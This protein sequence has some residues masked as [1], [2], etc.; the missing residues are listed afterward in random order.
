[1]GL[2]FLLNWLP[3]VVVSQSD[4]PD[5]KPSKEGG[6]A[7]LDPR[8]DEAGEEKRNI[9]LQFEGVPYMDALQRFSQMAE[10]PL[11]TDAPLDGTLTFFDSEPYTYQEAMDILNVILSMKGVALVE[12]GRYLQ[13]TTLENIQKMP[14]KVVRGSDTTGDFRPGQ[15][16]TVVLRLKHLDAGEVSSAAASLLSNA[17]SVAPLSRG[18]GL[19]ITDRLESIH[20]IQQLLAEIDVASAVERDMK[21]YALKHASGAVVS[22]LINKTFGKSSVPKQVKWNEKAKKFDSFDPDP[23]SYISSVYDEASRTLVLFGPVETLELA[24]ELI[25]EF[26]TGEG[27]AGEVKIF[28]P[29]KMNAEELAS[30]IREGV[31]GVAQKGET[32]A[33]AKLKARIIVDAKLN[34]VIA[35]APV[36][37]QLEIIENFVLQVDGTGATGGQRKPVTT[38][39]ITRVFR[40][41]SLD[42][43]AIRQA[44]TNATSDQLPAGEMRSRLAISVDTSTRSLIV[45]GSPG[46]VQTAEDIVRQL[47]QGREP[48]IARQT[49][50]FEMRDSE[51]LG[52]VTPLVEQLYK[53]QVDEAGTGPADAI[54]L[55]DENTHRLIV[56]AKPDHLGQIEK[57]ISELRLAKP[58]TKPRTTVMLPLANRKV[59]QVYR[60]IE[61]LV[62]DRMGE[63]PFRDQPKP[64]LIEDRVN[65]RVIVT[66]NVEQHEVVAQVVQSLDVLPDAPERTMR[67]VDLDGTDA[68]KVTPLISRLFDN[69]KP[70]AGPAPQVIEDTGGERLIVLS[71]GEQHGRITAFL[72]KYQSARPV[73]V[74]REMRVISLPRREPGKFNQALQSIQKLID[75]QMLNPEFAKLPKPMILPDESGSRLVM[76]ATKEQFAVIEQIVATVT[77]APEPVA[78]Q[79]RVLRLEDRNAAEM[80]ELA[81]RLFDKQISP[82]GTKPEIFTDKEGT[83]LIVVGTDAEYR[84]VEKMVSDYSS[85]REDLG[86]HQVKIVRV[87]LGQADSVV[88]SASQ[89]YQA[90]MRDNPGR[91]AT[92]AILIADSENDRNAR[93]RTTHLFVT[94]TWYKFVRWADLEQLSSDTQ[95]TFD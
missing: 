59:D 12:S 43:D 41:K 10:K 32:A 58:L 90:Q 44:V 47:E 62:N 13:L 69:D 80:L 85:G 17:G 11:I 8:T 30:M 35:S 61:S 83:R 26:E 84:Q 72:E 63:T 68:A 60:N 29:T 89:L 93:C 42:L 14:L 36:A 55:R 65:N 51:E 39:S 7:K 1:M 19:I 48:I 56:R 40:I 3:V 64:R 16:V 91:L 24:A 88:Q 45:T 79:M 4:S 6:G 94:S 38:V 53:E 5:S 9:R 46:D 71:T 73:V 31:D 86:P 57:L 52:R 37:G 75:Q 81:K 34:R 82:D 95:T 78:R 67:F 18:Q 33:A 70:S 20:R 50:I 77:A 76:T 66:A 28:H 25:G 2:S 23:S 87:P 27:K 92:P 22:E 54:I 15:I 49:R 21:T 74:A